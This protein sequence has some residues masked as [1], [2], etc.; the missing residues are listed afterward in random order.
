MDELAGLGLMLRT[1]SVLVLVCFGWVGEVFRDKKEKKKKLM[2]AAVG[3]VVCC[4]ADLE[5]A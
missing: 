5:F 4:V 1:R 3:R 2:K